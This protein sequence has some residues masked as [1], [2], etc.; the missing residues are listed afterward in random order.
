[1]EFSHRLLGGRK[2]QARER[3]EDRQIEAGKKSEQRQKDDG[4]TVVSASFDMRTIYIRTRPIPK[5]LLSFL[6]SSLVSFCR[7][8]RAKSVKSPESS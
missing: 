3:T 8:Y 7:F 2:K 5:D 4:R 1:M 6:S